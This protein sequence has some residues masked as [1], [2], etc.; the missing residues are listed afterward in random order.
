MNT[1]RNVC[2]IFAMS[3]FALFLIG[4]LMK[5]DHPEWG[6]MDC[7]GIHHEDNGEIGQSPENLKKFHALDRKLQKELIA[8]WSQK[9]KAKIAKLAKQKEERRRKAQE[10]RINENLRV[11]GNLVGPEGGQ[12]NDD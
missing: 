4:T 12:K 10:A 11:Y 3:V 7:Y 8:R 5:R 2:R 9:E 6:W 1:F